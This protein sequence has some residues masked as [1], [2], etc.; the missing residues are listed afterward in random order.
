[1]HL[2]QPVEQGEDQPLDRL[3]RQSLVTHQALAQRLALDQRHHHVG[4]AVGFE[5]V[6]HP[7]D[8]RAVEP[9]QGAGLVEEAFAA[10]RKLLGMVGRVRQHRGAALAQRQRRRQILLDGDVPMESGIHRPVGDAEGAL[11]KD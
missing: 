6:V 4:G 8:G 2:L 3:R 11:A 10:P 1:M 7:Y 5:E 9:S